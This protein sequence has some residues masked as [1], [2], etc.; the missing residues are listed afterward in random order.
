[1]RMQVVD[2][3]EQ[4]LAA[5]LSE[6]RAARTIATASPLSRSLSSC[7]SAASVDGPQTTS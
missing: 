7:A 2:A 1:M 5:Q 3:L 6:P 4:L